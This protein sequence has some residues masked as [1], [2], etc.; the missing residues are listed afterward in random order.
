MSGWF[1]LIFL[2]HFYIFYLIFLIIFFFM[3]E[4]TNLNCHIVCGAMHT[5]NCMKRETERENQ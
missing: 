3:E 1:R 4:L 2:I 5:Y